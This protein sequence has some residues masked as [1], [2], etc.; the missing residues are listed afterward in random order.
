MNKIVDQVVSKVKDNKIA[1]GVTAVSALALGAV[2]FFF[3][4]PTTT[5]PTPSDQTVG[6][7]AQEES[8]YM[9]KAREIAS[10]IR[11]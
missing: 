3:K 8:P 4:K 10:H 7:N 1:V 5:T 11:V 2:Y 9:K 6:N